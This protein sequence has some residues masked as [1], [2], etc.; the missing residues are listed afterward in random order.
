M[1]K[2]VINSSIQKA[3]DFLCDA[4]L[5]WGEFPAFGVNGK[6][7]PFYIKSVFATTFILHAL[8][9]IN[10]NPKVQQVK[11]RA[12]KFLLSERED[13]HLWRYFGK[14]SAISPDL[15]D[16]ACALAALAKNNNTIEPEICDQ[17]LKY[18]DPATGLF[19]TWVEKPPNS[20]NDT[21]S[22]VNANI[23]F[24]YGLLGKS[25]MIPE[26]VSYLIKEADV[27]HI[28]NSQVWYHSP[29]MFSYAVSRAFSD[30]NVAELD[31]TRLILIEHLLF[32]QQDIG[33]W[34]NPLETAFAATALLNFSYDGDAIDF[35]IK[36]LM[37]TQDPKE[38]TWRPDFFCYGGE[39]G[40][41]ELTTAMCVEALTKYEFMS[42]EQ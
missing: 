9:F 24:L 37:E 42:I 30:G 14:A 26:V 28:Q 21:D 7:K 12:I 29:Q 3:V 2:I 10:D 25:Q 15:D 13:S 23:L 11:E 38:S 27:L 5:G 17:L 6:G 33:C 19:K 41:K 1:N 16:T 18:R 39:A 34:C 20:E 8:S 40:S 31:P 36:F 4:Q 32:S 22:I 35:A